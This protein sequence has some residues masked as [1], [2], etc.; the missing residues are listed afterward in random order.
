MMNMDSGTIRTSG[1]NVA[2]KPMDIAAVRMNRFRRVNGTVDI[3]LIPEMATAEK[4]KVV[5]P[6][7]TELGIATSAAANLEKTPIMMR[8][9]QHA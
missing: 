1:T 7:S 6:P 4:R 9:K 2:P 8:K 3:I 5:I